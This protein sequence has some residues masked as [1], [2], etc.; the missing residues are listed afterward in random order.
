[1]QGIAP[2]R[3]RRHRARRVCAAVGGRRARDSSRGGLAWG[4]A[5][6]G[7][8]RRGVADLV[9][10]CSMLAGGDRVAGRVRHA[11]VGNVRRAPRGRGPAAGSPRRAPGRRPADRSRACGRA[12]GEPGRSG[13]RG[14]D[15]RR[16]RRPARRLS[17][18]SP[19]PDGAAA[20]RGEATPDR[21]P[22]GETGRGRRDSGGRH[23]SLRADRKDVC[24]ELSAKAVRPRVPRHGSGDGRG[25]R[26]GLGR[27]RAENGRR[28]A[29][30]GL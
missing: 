18:S 27:S 25:I 10:P 1:M 23:V 26:D 24:T 8:R 4:C 13:E 29:R 20:G 19:E 15:A 16:A 6:G 30:A 14:T 12:D 21:R 28:Q 3:C 5:V 2:G 22:L 9:P 11:G 17:G 7:R